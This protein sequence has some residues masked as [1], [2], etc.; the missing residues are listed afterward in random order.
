MQNGYQTIRK[1]KALGEVNNIFL[2]LCTL[3]QF[4]VLQHEYVDVNFKKLGS[5]SSHASFQGT[6]KRKGG[7]FHGFFQSGSSFV[8]AQLPDQHRGNTLSHT[9]RPQ[10]WRPTQYSL[11]RHCS[12]RSR[13]PP[14]NILAIDAW[15]VL[16]VHVAQPASVAAIE[17]DVFEVEGVNMAREIPE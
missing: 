14:L 5:M 11:S 3:I 6:N 13:T 12:I 8:T 2:H 4:R 10:S 9:F 1:F 7:G 17:I 16:I 15:C